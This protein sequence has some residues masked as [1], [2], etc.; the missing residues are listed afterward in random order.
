MAEQELGSWERPYLEDGSGEAHLLYQVHGCF[1]GDLRVSRSRHRCSGLPRGFDLQVYDG[2]EHADVAAFGTT[3]YFQGSFDRLPKAV[4]AAVNNATHVAVLRGSTTDTSTLDYLR[5]A[6]GLVQALLEGGGVAVFDPF[7]LQ[8]W[9]DS[10]WTEEV[11]APAAPRPAAHATILVSGEPGGTKWFHTRGM[12]KFARPD[13]SV[14]GVRTE[15]ERGVVELCNRFIRFQALGGV[16][17]HGQTIRMA[18]LPEWTCQ[19]VGTLDDP[20]FNNRRIE[21]GEGTTQ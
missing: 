12:L 9:S 21:V 19:T 14:R 17:P 4:R 3:G 15:Y 20:D 8:W 7:I 11:F 1:N 13:I 6:V 18:G 16:V 5:D 2:S 10:Q